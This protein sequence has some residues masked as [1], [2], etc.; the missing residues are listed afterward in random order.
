M[1]EAHARRHAMRKLIPRAREGKID[2]VTLRDRLAAMGFE[3]DLRTIQRDLLTMAMEEPLCSD[4]A[5][6]KGWWWSKDAQPE[7]FPPMD[8]QLALSFKLIEAHLKPLLPHATLDA[9]SPWFEQATQ[10]LNSRPTPLQRWQDKVAVVPRGQPL[11]PPKIRPACQEA[12]YDAVLR[13]R[14]IEVTYETRSAAR[15]KRYLLHPVGLVLKAPVTYLIATCWD[16]DEPKQFALHRIVKA[17]VRDESAQVPK[18]VSLKAYLAEGK[19]EL[20]VGPPIKLVARFAAGTAQHLEETPLSRDQTMEALPDG[21]VRMTASVADTMAL[22]WWLRGFGPH[23]EV[24]SPSR[25]LDD[26]D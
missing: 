3:V 7:L 12:V 25:L 23:V 10:I 1:S 21:W 17:S 20:R 15:T 6:P 26:P 22:R 2:A 13:E 8:P 11:L 24:E 14:Q 18:G 5:R 19:M 9:L 4:E 16:Y